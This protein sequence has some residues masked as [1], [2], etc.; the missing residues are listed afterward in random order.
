VT[1]RILHLP[2]TRA[3][4]DL[5]RQAMRDSGGKWDYPDGSGADHIDWDQLAV[6]VERDLAELDKLVAEQRE[7]LP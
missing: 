3:G 1:A 4:R 6:E 7:A 5:V 2:Q